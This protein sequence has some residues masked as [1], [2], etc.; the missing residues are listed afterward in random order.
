MKR[1]RI[2]ASVL[3]TVFLS[4]F[5]FGQSKKNDYGLGLAAA[6]VGVIGII[7]Q[8]EKYKELIENKA[9]SY[10]IKN[11]P[12]I[13]QFRLQVM[14]SG[15]D[16]SKLS[17]DG[18]MN[19][20]PIELTVLK[21]GKTTRDRKILFLL[22]DNNITNEYGLDYSLYKFD[23]WDNIKWNKFIKSASYLAS[24]IKNKT[25]DL[26]MPVYLKTKEKHINSDFVKIGEAEFP[27]F[28]AK[29]EINLLESIDIRLLEFTK[30]GLKYDFEIIF[31]FYNLNRDDY[32]VS[33]FESDKKIIYNE[34]SLGFFDIKFNESVLFKRSFVNRIHQFLNFQ[35]IVY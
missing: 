2:I 26:M 7:E 31:P 32:L 3:I 18:D 25:E 16:I 23:L 13:K 15:A 24:P 5:C 34:N 22:I 8:I 9:S 30:N 11:H 4:N 17:D 28:Y 33:D 35:D 27:I 19:V 21:N 29:S 14:G 6:T 20:L 1:Y 12:E 10:I